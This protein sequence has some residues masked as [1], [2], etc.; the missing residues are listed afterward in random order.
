VIADIVEE[1]SFL[2]QGQTGQEDPEYED[3]TNLHGIPSQKI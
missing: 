3:I 2:L 1:H